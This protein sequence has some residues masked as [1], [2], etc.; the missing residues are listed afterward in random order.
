MAFHGGTFRAGN[1]MQSAIWKQTVSHEDAAKYNNQIITGYS[2]ARKFF[3]S[4][5]SNLVDDVVVRAST[6][7]PTS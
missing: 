5:F 4:R 3:Q 7:Q 1:N 6:S 2:P